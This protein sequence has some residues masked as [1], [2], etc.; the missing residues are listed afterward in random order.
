MA[1]SKYPPELL[2][3]KHEHADRC[4][5]W[6]L[7]AAAEERAAKEGG[8]VPVLCLPAARQGHYLVCIHDEDFL[9]F[10]ANLIAHMDAWERAELDLLIEL[11]RARRRSAMAGVFRVVGEED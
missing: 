5:T 3:V 11:A 10:A 2:V 7:Y 8:K 9:H 6:M 4:T 1:G